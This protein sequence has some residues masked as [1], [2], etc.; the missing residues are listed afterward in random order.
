MDPIGWT[1]ERIREGTATGDIDPVEVV[2]R[3]L[4]RIRSRNPRINAFLYTDEAGALRAAE[5][6][7]ER[8]RRGGPPGWLLGVPVAVKDNQCTA[9]TPTTA[10]SAMLDGYRP[11]YAAH[12]V[13]RIQEEGGIIVGKTNLDEFGMGSSCEHSAFG[14][15]RHPQDPERTPGGSSGGSAAAVAD[16]MACLATGSDTGGSIRLPASL[17]GIVGLKPTYGRVSRHGLVAYASSMDQIGPLARGV[18]DAA[19]M[20]NALAGRDPR[21]ATSSSRPVPDYRA[22][23]ER[24]V[25]GLRLGLMEESMGEGLDAEVERAVRGAAEAL[26]D[27]GAEV[28][29]CSLPHTAYA[30][31]AYYVTAM[32]EASSNLA[33]YDGVRYGFR[34]PA[35]SAAALVAG[36]RGR[37][38]GLEVKRRV[39][40]GA[41]VLSAGYADAYYRKAARIRT[42]VRR[43]FERAFA[44]GLDA[45]IGPT[46]PHRAIRLGERVDD[47]VR[48][49]LEDVHTVS[50][51]LAGLPAVSV[52]AGKAGDG[53][54]AGVQILGGPFEEGTILRIGRAV[55]KA[56]GGA[57]LLDGET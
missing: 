19:L 47:P 6:V 51:N 42:L 20:M 18:R 45:L 4:E 2:E 29:P 37:G 11:P 36:S 39:L 34:A 56:R 7:Q 25:R 14:P 5:R 40:L 41:F 50:A 26:R 38:F 24:G 16:G 28:V 54:P 15:V 30:A 32:A 9:G 57:R 27:Q 46:C 8:V 10:G 23:L 35:S 21:D 53:L 22:D 31:T 43:D 3:T 1:A 13:E 49:Y 52:P 48:M 12:V 44:T 55:E 33:R 17:C